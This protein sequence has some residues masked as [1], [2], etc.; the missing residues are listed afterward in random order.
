M[1]PRT[2]QIKDGL[3]DLCG[4]YGV[5]VTQGTQ[6]VLEHEGRLFHMTVQQVH[7]GE[8]HFHACLVLIKNS[9]PP[10]LTK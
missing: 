10:Q 7:W 1:M 9:D 8:K 3:V 2:L 4:G 6:I 5:L